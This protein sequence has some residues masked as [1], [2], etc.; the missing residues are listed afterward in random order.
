MII[1]YGKPT[2][3]FGFETYYIIQKNWIPADVKGFDS[4][5]KTTSGDGIFYLPPHQGSS[6]VVSYIK[7]LLNS[8]DYELSARAKT[9]VYEKARAEDIEHTKKLMASFDKKETT[10]GINPFI[11]QTLC[12]IVDQYVSKTHC[13]NCKY[14]SHQF[15]MCAK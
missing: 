1:E 8:G 15:Q 14:Y 6:Y 4:C 11:G 2:K 3:N 12:G 10:E 5:D 9:E 7:K 13:K